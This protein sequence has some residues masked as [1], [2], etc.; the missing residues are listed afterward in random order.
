VAD[1]FAQIVASIGAK[2]DGNWLD[3][4][5][6][7]G[8]FLYATYQWYKSRGTPPPQPFLSKATAIDLANGTGLVPLLTLGLVVFSSSLLSELLQANKLILSTAG[9]T[10]LLSILD[11]T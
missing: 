1:S 3:M 9:W 10:A 5:S 4:L 7:G 11:E 6:L 2:I 8:A